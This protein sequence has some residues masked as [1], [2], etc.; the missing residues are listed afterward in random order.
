MIVGY[1]DLTVYMVMLT[2]LA[3]PLGRYIAGVYTGQIKILAII[4]RPLY[5]LIGVNSE[6]TWIEYAFGIM[7]FNIL[8]IMFINNCLNPCFPLML[9]VK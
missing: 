3:L 7:L 2:I 5:R 1:I 9:L 4:E 8:G 6:M